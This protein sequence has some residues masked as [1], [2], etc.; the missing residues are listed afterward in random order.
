MCSEKKV[1]EWEVAVLLWAPS[2]P[3][4]VQHPL[5]R[6]P[7]CTG[8]LAGE[9]RGG[10]ELRGEQRAVVC[11]FFRALPGG[12]QSPDLCGRPLAMRCVCIW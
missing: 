2:H 12:S 1:H 7:S 9:Q 3:G 6:P 8:F 11:V 10:R 5:F 4:L